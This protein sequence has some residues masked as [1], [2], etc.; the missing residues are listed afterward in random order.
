VDPGNAWIVDAFGCDPARL[1]SPETLASV[2]KECV[3]DLRLT[4]ISAAVWHAFPDPGGVTGFLLLSE[5]HLS[6]HTFPE[7][8]FA[9]FDLYCCRSRADWPWAER[10]ASLLGASGVV[11]RSLP[12]GGAGGR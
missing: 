1:R 7:R 4:P 3:A 12:R 10:L 9:A 6:V 2:F 8:G 5:S 11:V